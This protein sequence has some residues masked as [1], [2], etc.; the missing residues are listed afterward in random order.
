[1]LRWAYGPHDRTQ[2]SAATEP[3]AAWIGGKRLLARRTIERI[4]AIPHRC[5]AE[6]FVGMVSVFLRQ[7]R[8]PNSSKT[9][10]AVLRS[11]LIR[12]VKSC[13]VSVYC[14]CGDFGV[15]SNEAWELTITP[16]QCRMARAGL[17]WSQAEL[18]RRSGV[19]PSTIAAFEKG[20][21]TPYPRTIRDLEENS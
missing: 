10:D 21:R 8:K 4:D 12:V 15:A 2:V 16:E 13:N 11:I 7:T 1:M 3:L 19:A 9:I 6:P 18:S 5:Y 20:L 17:K 14:S